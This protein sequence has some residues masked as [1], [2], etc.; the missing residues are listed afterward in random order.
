MLLM[1]DS[2]DLIKI[3]INIVL[4]TLLTILDKI[5]IFMGVN[6]HRNQT[7]NSL[8]EYTCKTI[9]WTSNIILSIMS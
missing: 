4:M 2:Y 6:I 8:I 3:S 7:L 5:L 1:N 9:F